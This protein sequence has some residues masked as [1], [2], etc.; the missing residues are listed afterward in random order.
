[1]FEHNY[2]VEQ[3]YVK[4]RERIQEDIKKQLEELDLKR[5]EE[6]LKSVGDN[7]EKKA[8]IEQKYADLVAELS[9]GKSK[10]TGRSR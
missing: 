2:N 7:A 1:M 9:E 6:V 8:E 10:T 4:K 3:D 5:Q